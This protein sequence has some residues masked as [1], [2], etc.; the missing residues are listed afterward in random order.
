M[1]LHL[2]RDPH[3]KQVFNGLSSF[4]LG[5]RCVL[6][7]QTKRVAYFA[8]YLSRLVTPA[9]TKV[10]MS[11][12]SAWHNRNGFSSPTSRTPILKLVLKGAKRVHAHNTGSQNRRQPITLKVLQTL[13]RP[14]QSSSRHLNHC[15][16][17]MLRAAFTLAFYDLLHISEFTVP[18]KRA[19]D[20]RRNTTMADISWGSQ[21]YTLT[22]K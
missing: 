5:I 14:L 4:V 1:P 18:S 12:I 11:A 3:T 7:Q 17:R 19:F 6:Y 21:H 10:Y 16:E 2:P 20:P 9:T 8:V 15:D 22:V 13:L